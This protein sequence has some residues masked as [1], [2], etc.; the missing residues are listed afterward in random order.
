MKHIDPTIAIALKPY[1]PQISKLA[2]ATV[3]AFIKAINAG[4]EDR[5]DMI[6]NQIYNAKGPYGEA[7]AA[8]MEVLNAEPCV[9]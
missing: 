8:I 9:S 4:D 3:D 2:M 6:D 5:A 7:L 1:S